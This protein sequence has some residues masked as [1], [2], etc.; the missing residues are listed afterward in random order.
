[1][2]LG[3]GDRSP[4]N[5]RVGPDLA[6]EI[7]D[8]AAIGEIQCMKIDPRDRIDLEARVIQIDADHFV[9]VRESVD[10]PLARSPQA[11]GHQ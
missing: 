7:E 9:L 5:Y 1:M 3:R 10:D 6:H 11:A 8:L 4:V 2:A